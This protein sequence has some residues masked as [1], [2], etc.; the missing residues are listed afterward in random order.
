MSKQNQTEWRCP[1]CDGL[2]DWQDEVCQICGDGKRDEVVSS[3][4]KKSSAD[5]QQPTRKDVRSE[6][7]QSAPEPEVRR[8]RPEPEIRKPEPEVKKT[9][10][11]VKY[12][13][14]RSATPAKKPK[15]KK[16]WGLIPVAAVLIPVAA[17]LIAGGLYEFSVHKADTLVKDIDFKLLEEAPYTSMD[18]FKSWAE[19]QGYEV[20]TSKDGTGFFTDYSVN[21]GKSDWNISVSEGNRSVEI[22]YE[23]D[24]Q[25]LNEVYKKLEDALKDR[26]WDDLDFLD[27]NPTFIE[28]IKGKKYRDTQ[29]WIDEKNNWYELVLNDKQITITREDGPASSDEMVAEVDL[30]FLQNSPQE[31]IQDSESWLKQNGYHYTVSGTAHYSNYDIS[32]SKSADWNISYIGH[33]SGKSFSVAYRAMEKDCTDLPALYESL[34]AKLEISGFTIVCQEAK[35]SEKTDGSSSKLII[36]QD[37][38]GNLYDLS[39]VEGTS[40]GY[41]GVNLVKENS[42]DVGD[43]NYDIADPADQLNIAALATMPMNSYIGDEN[44]KQKFNKNYGNS[45]F[46]PVDMSEGDNWCRAMFMYFPSDQN[47]KKELLRYLKKEIQDATG[48]KMQLDYVSLSESGFDYYYEIETEQSRIEFS[49]HESSESVAVYIE[50]NRD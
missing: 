27:E 26:N 48:K 31:N 39:L 4:K 16:H 20:T 45:N 41:N 50:S 33:P 35:T 8:S 44:W 32:N 40:P 38:A 49:S 37:A 23:A 1:Y 14:P 12:S 9:E 43:Y 30:D 42:L 3:E 15:K 5:S 47:N 10:P 36:W 28:G 21:P 29:L 11:E 34:K 17:V 19:N 25:N 2:N 22:K 18:G 6:K 13:E 7:K 24:G 46:Q